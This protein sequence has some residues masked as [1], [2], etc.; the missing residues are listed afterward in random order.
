MP[1]SRSEDEGH[2]E[3]PDQVLQSVQQLLDD[4][5]VPISRAVVVAVPVPSSVLWGNVASAVNSAWAAMAQALPDEA[6]HGQ[7][8]AEALLADRRL[9]AEQHGL[10]PEFRRSSCCLLI[11][12]LT[13]HAHGVC[14]DCPRGPK[15]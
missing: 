8:I 13:E 2:G 5:L 3:T 4:A 9:G 15:A 11:R 6:H 14:A 12:T 1:G 7:W 10:G